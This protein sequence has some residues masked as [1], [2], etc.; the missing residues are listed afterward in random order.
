MLARTANS[1]SVRQMMK[2]CLV[3][4]Y[5][6]RFDEDESGEIDEMEGKQLLTRL[7]LNLNVR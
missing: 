5:L 3:A 2:S 1:G 7:G 4:R 6:P